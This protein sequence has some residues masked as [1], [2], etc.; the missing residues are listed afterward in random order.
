MLALGS[1]SALQTG[2]RMAGKGVKE[3]RKLED[4]TGGSGESWYGGKGTSVVS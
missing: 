3:A 2:D 1:Y 4:P